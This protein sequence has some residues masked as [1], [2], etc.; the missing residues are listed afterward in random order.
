VRYIISLDYLNPSTSP[1]VA[2]VNQIINRTTVAVSW[3]Y[4][5]LERTDICDDCRLDGRSGGWVSSRVRPRQDRSVSK[6]DYLRR[7]PPA[8][9]A[10][11]KAPNALELLF[12]YSLAGF[13]ILF[14]LV[15]NIFFHITTYRS[16]HCSS[17]QLVPTDLGYYGRSAAVALF[18]LPE[19]P[20]GLS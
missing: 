18:F 10:S 12:A 7:G 15:T 5:C 2:C 1:S 6:P 14:M 20:M 13:L 8:V 3:S 9:I 11:R 19:G 17:P 4:E 16:T